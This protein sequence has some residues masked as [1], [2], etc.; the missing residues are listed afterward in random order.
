V[1]ASDIPAHREV[2]GSGGRL[3]PPHDVAEW[4]MA[5][6]AARE[7]MPRTAPWTLNDLA[8][9]RQEFVSSIEAFLMR[10]P[11]RAKIAGR[12]AL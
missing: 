12:N 7:A 1:I 9:A 8:A 11:T 6:L 3:L 4:S 10:R 5:V 2:M